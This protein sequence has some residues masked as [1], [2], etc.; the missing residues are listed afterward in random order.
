MFSK[1]N[2]K[3]IDLD[4]VAQDLSQLLKGG[5]VVLFVADMG[6]GKTTLISRIAKVLG[7]NETVT[8]PTF[9]IVETYDCHTESARKGTAPVNALSRTSE[10]SIRKLIHIDTYRLTHVN[11][12]YDL[13]FETIFNDEA[14]TLVEWGE[15]IEEFID[16]DH[17]VLTIEEVDDETRN[18]SL[19]YIEVS[20]A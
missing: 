16:K 14:L 12:L 5:D 6:S 3:L 1:S 4:S 9:A 17:Y 18:I 19:K 13:G 20:N 15:R 11:E 10:E 2:V 8:S 7:V